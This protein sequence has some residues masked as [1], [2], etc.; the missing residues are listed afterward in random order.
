[1]TSRP[2]YA[3]YPADYARDTGHLT[4]LEHGAYRIL[5]DHCYSQGNLISANVERLCRLCRASTNDEIDAL[6]YVLQ[7]FFEKTPD[8]Y[9][10]SRVAKE[11]E[12][13]NIFAERAAKAGRAS[14]TKRQ[15]DRNSSSTQVDGKNQLE[16]NLSQSQSQ[17]QEERKTSL[18]DVQ[19]KGTRWP[20]DQSVSEDW[21]QLA[22]MKRAEHGLAQVNLDLVAETFVNYWI[23]KAGQNGTKVDWQKTWINWALKAENPRNGNGKASPHANFA[24]GAYLAA[25]R[26]R[27]GT[28]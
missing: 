18:R 17:S 15:L 3:F 25:T 24:A 14:A 22:G 11:L 8:G 19:R 20:L 6:E 13:A 9:R 5:L 28:Q 4:L 10:H 2:W 12:T 16:G 7:Q 26:D 23:G 1:M 27:S 21:K